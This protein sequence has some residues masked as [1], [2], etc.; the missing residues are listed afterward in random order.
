[1]Y[2]EILDSAS[3]AAEEAEWADANQADEEY[4]TPLEAAYK[5]RAEQLQA[6]IDFSGV[7]KARIAEECGM[8]PTYLNRALS[9][10]LSIPRYIRAV[11][12]C[13]D[14]PINS[15][16]GLDDV[17]NFVDNKPVFAATIDAVLRYRPAA[18]QAHG[19]M[20]RAFIIRV[21]ENYF[22]RS[23][24]LRDELIAYFRNPEST[25]D[26]R[27][28]AVMCLERALKLPPET[29]SSPDSVR[30][31]KDSASALSKSTRQIIKE[32]VEVLMEKHNYSIPD[33]ATVSAVSERSIKRLLSDDHVVSLTLLM[34]I[35]AGLKVEP[36]I[37]LM[38]T[39]DEIPEK[40][41]F[42]IFEGLP[43]YARDLIILYMS[44]VKDKG[45]ENLPSACSRAVLLATPFIM[46]A[47]EFLAAAA[48]KTP[49]EP[50]DFAEL[51]GCIEG[52]LRVGAIRNTVPQDVEKKALLPP[53]DN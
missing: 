47:L 46:N 17:E 23:I 42:K 43:R 44:L 22:T 53:N 35:A 50:M 29:I 48:R 9:E 21:I 39:S 37:L 34:A 3:R 15:I 27:P 41:P 12:Q 16:S 7:S 36:A 28:D 6:C 5:M 24:D 11:E 32:N 2:A 20:P 52:L 33:L 38:P 18:G 14:L 30:S 26:P 51:L 31:R 19:E 4:E 10:G 49:D 8:S 25:E 1:M 45:N 40:E 13:F